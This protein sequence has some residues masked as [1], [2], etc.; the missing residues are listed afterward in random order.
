MKFARHGALHYLRVNLLYTRRSPLAFIPN[1]FA[2]AVAAPGVLS[3]PFIQY[4][5]A[6]FAFVGVSIST[7]PVQRPRLTPHVGAD[8]H[9]MM[10]S[11]ETQL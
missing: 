1:L 6:I 8:E 3:P 5:R 2:V 4:A 10:K 11:W 9:G 7:A